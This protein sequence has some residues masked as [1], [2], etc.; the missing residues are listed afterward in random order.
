MA[1]LVQCDRCRSLVADAFAEAMWY[2]VLR[3]DEDEVWLCS[4]VCISGWASEPDLSGLDENN[5]EDPD[6]TPGLADA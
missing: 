5:G 1:R 3:G 4:I 2:R 6:E